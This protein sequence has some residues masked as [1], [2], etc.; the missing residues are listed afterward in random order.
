MGLAADVL[1]GARPERV[2]ELVLIGV[3]E[4]IDRLGFCHSEQLRRIGDRRVAD[5]EDPPAERG[6]ALV[7]VG[8]DDLALERLPRQAIVRDEA[9]VIPL[10]YS[11]EWQLS[12]DGLLGASEN[13]LGIIRMA[14][15]AWRG[16]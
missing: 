14:G 4:E 1:P 15:M 16:K 11:K 7:P 5:V 8:P 13:G 10:S 9:P 2:V 6:V 3:D 12:R